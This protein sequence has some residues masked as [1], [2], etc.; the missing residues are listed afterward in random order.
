MNLGPTKNLCLLPV[1]LSRRP[2]GHKWAKLCKLSGSFKPFGLSGRP[3]SNDREHSG[4]RLFMTGALGAERRAS[5]PADV[6]CSTASIDAV[7]GALRIPSDA[8]WRA[9]RRARSAVLSRSPPRPRKSRSRMREKPTRPGTLRKSLHSTVATSRM[10][11]W[12]CASPASL[13]RIKMK[14]YGLR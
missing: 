12:R 8:R 3:L 4:V 9:L 7:P 14:I 6:R 11:R 1:N 2:A 5:R 13:S 10:R